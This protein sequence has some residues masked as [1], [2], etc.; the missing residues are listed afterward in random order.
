MLLHAQ[1]VRVRVL[2]DY[3]VDALLPH[4]KRIKV[5]ENVHIATVLDLGGYEALEVALIDFDSGILVTSRTKDGLVEHAVRA[6]LELLNPLVVRLEVEHFCLS[7]GQFIL[8]FGERSVSDQFLAQ[9][10]KKEASVADAD[11]ELVV[12]VKLY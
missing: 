3:V 7:K 6:E 1:I 4:A 2:R 12:H 11:E 10:Y 9:I 5:F 8:T